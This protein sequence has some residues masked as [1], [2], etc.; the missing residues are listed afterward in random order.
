VIR[1]IIA[2]FIE[3]SVKET[4]VTPPEFVGETIPRRSYYSIASSIRNFPSEGAYITCRGPLFTECY[5]RYEIEITNVDAFIN[6][7]RAEDCGTRK[8][9]VFPVRFRH[10]DAVVDQA[11]LAKGFYIVTGAVPYNSP[12]D[13]ADF[14]GTHL[15]IPLRPWLF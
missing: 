14:N 3:Q 13:C 8:T 10:L 12:M 2:D 6:N 11:L 7:Y 15:Q 1:K 9:W 5:N 4:K